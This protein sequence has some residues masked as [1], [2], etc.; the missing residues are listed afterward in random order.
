MSNKKR[1]KIVRKK[2]YTQIGISRLKCLRCGKPAYTQWQI[3]SDDRN[4]RPACIE[5]DIELNEL[6][7]KFFRHPF[8]SK[9]MTKYRKTF[10]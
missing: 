6:V 9:L 4:Y 10:E 2:P 3:C 1:W 7:L 5:C 8:A